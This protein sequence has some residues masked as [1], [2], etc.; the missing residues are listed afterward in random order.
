M[1][2]PCI[3]DQLATTDGSN[4]SIRLGNGNGTLLNDD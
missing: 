2:L 4:V 1:S 3:A